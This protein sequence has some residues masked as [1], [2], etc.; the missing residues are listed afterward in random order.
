M[1]IKKDQDIRGVEL[2]L[3]RRAFE[4]TDYGITDATERREWR[5]RIE[6]LSGGKNTVVY[7]AENMPSVMVRVPSKMQ[8]ELDA[9]FPDQI[10][11][12]FIVN[13]NVKD[14]FLI[15]KYQAFIAVKAATNYAL[16]LAGVDPA[17]SIDFDDSLTACANNGTGHHLATQPEWGFL[18]LDTYGQG[19]EPRGNT[20]YG[21]S[22]IRSDEKGRPGSQD[23]GNNEIDR[24]MTG[25]GPCAWSHDGSPFGIYDLVGNVWEWVG[26]YRVND[27]EINIL[28]NNN[29]ADNTKSQAAGSS[30]WQALLQDGSLVAPL[31]ADTLKWFNEGGV[32]E[33]NIVT[34]GTN[35]TWNAMFKDTIVE[36]GVNVPDL[37]KLLAIYPAQTDMQNGRFYNRNYDER[38]AL[39]GGYWT[40]GSN[41]GVFAVAL[42]NDRTR[43]ASNVGF[44]PAFVNL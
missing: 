1:L 25:S 11:P 22:H 14:E 18:A 36:A 13:G 42:N 20:N 3:T 2:A 40:D 31:T 35:E 23:T 4:V 21:S 33:L 16:S 12:A 32:N 6:E 37:L 27:G 34:N 39:R 5:E 38:I 28:A 10:H 30:E 43:T 29:A 44:R 24:I 15:G 8:S 7:N 41:A 19:F 26:G 9:Q 17:V